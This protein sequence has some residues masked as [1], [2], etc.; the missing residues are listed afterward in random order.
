MH[1][2]NDS[3]AQAAF[4]RL[5]LTHRALE[6]MLQTLSQLKKSSESTTSAKALLAAQEASKITPPCA[7]PAVLSDAKVED[8][9]EK[10]EEVDGE[11]TEDLNEGSA[12][13]CARLE[14]FGGRKSFDMFGW[15]TSKHRDPL[16][17]CDAYVVLDELLD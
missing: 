3:E 6:F 16:R 14:K 13:G 10:R 12:S 17:E 4:Q 11:E 9:P 7:V 15:L 1:A 2:E 5:G 8:D